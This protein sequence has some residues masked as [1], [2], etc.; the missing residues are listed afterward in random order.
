MRLFLFGCIVGFVGALLVR[1]MR[2]TTKSNW[3]VAAR[4]Y[5]SGKCSLSDAFDGLYHNPEHSARDLDRTMAERHGENLLRRDLAIVA[6]ASENAVTDLFSWADGRGPEAIRLARG[7][8]EAHR[9][10]A[11]QVE[12]VRDRLREE[13]K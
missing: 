3:E 13:Q 9:P 8:R 1:R 10:F 12:L 4:Y 6:R 11:E 7:L 2:H 5:Y